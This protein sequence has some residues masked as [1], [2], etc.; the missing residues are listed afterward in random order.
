MSLVLI[1]DDEPGLLNALEEVVTGM[2][3]EALGATNGQEALKLARERRPNLIISDQMMP[4]MTG[5]DLLREV[6]SDQNLA[7]TPCILMKRAI[8]LGSVGTCR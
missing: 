4:R 2:G 3:H 1:A 6:R 7:S 8:A 5:L